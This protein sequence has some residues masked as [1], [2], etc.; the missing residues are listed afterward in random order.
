MKNVI[1]EYN[2]HNQFPIIQNPE[3]APTSMYASYNEAEKDVHTSENF[4]ECDKRISP[5]R[6]DKYGCLVSHNFSIV[7]DT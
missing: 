3:S 6:Y 2:I 4:S 7:M 5:P 1:L